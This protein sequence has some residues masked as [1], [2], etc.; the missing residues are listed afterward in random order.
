MKITGGF[1]S[2]LILIIIIALVQIGLSQENKKEKAPQ[3]MTIANQQK[4][5]EEDL[6]PQEEKEVEEKKSTPT[7]ETQLKYD[8]DVVEI[9]RESQRNL[10]RS[11]NVLNIVATLAGILVGLLTLII[12]IAIA[13]GFFEIRRWRRV[14]NR[15][16]KV[17]EEAK[18]L[19]TSL[20]EYLAKIRTEARKLPPI[21]LPEKPSGDIKKKLDDLSQKLEFVEALGLD[22]EAEDY[23]ERATHLYYRGDYLNVLSAL[24]KAIELNP[25]NH[26]AWNNKSAVLI[27]LGRYKEALD[28]ANE[29]INLNPK[30]GMAW[31]NKSNAL[32]KLKRYNEALEVVN[33]GLSLA[34]G[35][36][37]LLN[38]K[39]IVFINLGRFDEALDVFDEILE[40][41][42]DN[43]EAY[44][45]KACLFSK[46]GEKDKALKN[47]S[48]AIDYDEVFKAKAK[49]D[50]DFK[51]LWNDADFIAIVG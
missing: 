30:Y 20:E 21:S 22:L 51:S 43:A 47:L 31:A 13:L 42:P 33:K 40:K 18:K 50:E 17:A 16:E 14:R 5:I 32:I 45:N 36:M 49:T 19:K 3:E 46:K 38:S 15:I 10:D 26:Q 44:Y 28:S 2:V 7:R 39:G 9:L 11:I 35:N 4:P 27:E 48:K 41:E 8:Y 12:I 6:K 34:P 1:L 29:A 25:Y 37:S 23:V 24:N